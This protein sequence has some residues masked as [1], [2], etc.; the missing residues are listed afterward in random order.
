MV[1]DVDPP[2][3]SATPPAGDEPAKPPKPSILDMLAPGESLLRQ[4]QPYIPTD[5][6][7][8]GIKGAK[9]SGP[10]WFEHGVDTELRR[11]IPEWLVTAAWAALAWLLADKGG[12][13]GGLIALYST[14][15][16]W[17]SARLLGL[18]K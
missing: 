10:G 2:E 17:I 3:P 13:L 7:T 15:T 14:A 18:L 16:L 1:P 8:S 9:D 4:P 11:N 5:I 12:E 6:D